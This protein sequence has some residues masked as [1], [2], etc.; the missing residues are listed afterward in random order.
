MII[1]CPNCATR[2]QADASKFPAAGRSVRCAKCSHVWHQLGPVPE[3]DP[4]AELVVDSAPTPPPAP[5]PPPAPAMAVEPEPEPES[6]PE[7]EP[8]PAAEP[9]P[10][11]AHEP[12]AAAF[13]PAPAV[14]TVE[15]HDV[16]ERTSTSTSAVAAAPRASWL[17]RIAVAGGWVLLVALVLMIGWSAVS[18]RDSI[19]TWVPQTSSFY[20]A[21]GLPVSPR[22]LD[23]VDVAYDN[24]PQGGQLVLAV[25]GKVVNHSGHELNVPLVMVSLYDRG[26]RELYHW[27]FEPGVSTLKPGEVAKFRTRLASPPGGTHSLEVR[28]AKAG[29]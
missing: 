1:T 4:D 5:S 16:L 23:L 22:G 11:I 25:T 10:V 17:G 8:E 2:Y 12:R 27:T 3:P 18:F 26:G 13:A 15:S 7:P 29:E 14:A 6:E 28:F 21:A 19:A 20:S 24:Q 9:E